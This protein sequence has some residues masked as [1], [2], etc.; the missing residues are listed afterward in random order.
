MKPLFRCEYCDKIGTAADIEQH[1]SECIYNK[2]KRS[3][4]TCKF[5][6]KHGLNFS[7]GCGKQI[8][9]GHYYLD[10][11]AYEDDGEDRSTKSPIQANSWGFFL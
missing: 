10:C 8:E 3:C 5:K 4:F 7:C 1:E 9:A 11:L 2:T 6:I